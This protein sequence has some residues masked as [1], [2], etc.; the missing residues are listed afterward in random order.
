[1]NKP[2][3][4]PVTAGELAR[5]LDTYPPDALLFSNENGGGGGEICAVVGG[6]MHL[7]WGGW[8]SGDDNVHDWANIPWQEERPRPYEETS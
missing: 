7:V 8:T 6:A 3:R 2:D 1:M 5:A 4:S